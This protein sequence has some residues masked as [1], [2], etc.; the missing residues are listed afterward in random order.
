MSTIQQIFEIELKRICQSNLLGIRSGPQ[1]DDGYWRLK[2]D[3]R[4][5]IYKT[6]KLI[7]SWVLGSRVIHMTN[8]EVLFHTIEQ[9]K[10]CDYIGFLG[11]K[12]GKKQC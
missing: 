6:L 4:R 7:L 3:E 9:Y 10:R 5:D 8:N 12:Y 2:H 11:L 1:E